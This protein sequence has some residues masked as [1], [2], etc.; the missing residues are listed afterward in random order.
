MSYSPEHSKLLI[1]I[2][3]AALLAGRVAHSY[4]VSQTNENFRFR[5][6]GMLLTLGVII[7]TSVRLLVDYIDKLL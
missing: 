7:S 1:H 4:G 6:T 3:G 5:V 2:L